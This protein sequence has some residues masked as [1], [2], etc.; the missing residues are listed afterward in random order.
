MVINTLPLRWEVTNMDNMTMLQF[1]I[2]QFLKSFSY[3]MKN[4]VEIRF[5]DSETGEV[6]TVPVGNTWHFSK[7]PWYAEEYQFWI[8]D[9]DLDTSVSESIATFGDIELRKEWFE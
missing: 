4:K 1:Q 9:K 3:V 5:M 2:N 7:L 6:K 8:E